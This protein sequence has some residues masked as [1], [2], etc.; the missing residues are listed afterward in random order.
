MISFSHCRF[1]R[2]AQRRLKGSRA[3]KKK[4]RRPVWGRR[5]LVILL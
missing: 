5:V 4:T 2:R 3:L 1:S